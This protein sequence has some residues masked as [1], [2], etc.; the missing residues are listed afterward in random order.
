M[1]NDLEGRS[2]MQAN[3]IVGKACMLANM[4][5]FCDDRGMASFVPPL[6]RMRGVELP[7]MPRIAMPRIKD[8]KR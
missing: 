4:W 5:Q 6:F 3:S 1:T 8:T 2:A 7:I